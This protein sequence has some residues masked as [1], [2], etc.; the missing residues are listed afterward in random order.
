[1]NYITIAMLVNSIP[2][3]FAHFEVSSSHLA[4]IVRTLMQVF[5]FFRQEFNTLLPWYNFLVTDVYIK[6]YALSKH[7]YSF[8]IYI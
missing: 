5:L 6:N 8:I 4:I 7:V 2:F 3:E 1:M